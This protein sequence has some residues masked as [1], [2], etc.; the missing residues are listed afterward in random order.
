MRPRLYPRRNHNN[1]GPIYFIAL[2]V[3]FLV[4]SLAPCV[5]NVHNPIVAMC[6]ALVGFLFPPFVVFLISG[7]IEYRRD[8]LLFDAN[9]KYLD[10]RE[11]SRR[12]FET[13]ILVREP[14]AI[15]NRISRPPGSFLL[16]L[17]DFFCSEKTQEMIAIPTI[18]DMR[19]EY[20]KALSQ[21]RKIKATWIRARGFWSFICALGLE[22]LLK[23]I[24]SLFRPAGPRG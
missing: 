24:G 20:H 8:G 2:A 14:L 17:S 5:L 18:T 23:T 15:K 7:L 19:I 13:P 16:F 3:G 22:R 12:H 11:D 1:S 6:Y 21:K 10:F 9:R 4:G